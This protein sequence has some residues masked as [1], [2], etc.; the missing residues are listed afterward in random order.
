[1]NCGLGNLFTLKAHLQGIV[2]ADET[3]FDDVVQAI[4]LGVAAQ[5]ENFCDRK[6]ARV[7]GDTF[8]SPADRASFIL[9]RYP[10][11]A[12]TLVEFKADETIGWVSGAGNVPAVQ[13][14]SSPSGLVYLGD[15]ADPG[16]YWSQVRFTFTGGYWFETLEPA[17]DGYP[18]ALPAGAAALPAD[19]LLAW[20]TQCRRV[21]SAFDKLGTKIVDNS[22]AA[23]AALAALDWTPESREILARYRRMTLI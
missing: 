2:L 4:G 9:P 10:V 12:V 23:S 19:L 13:S 21:W 15:G 6:L 14:L 11:E 20:L 18:S 1:M 17:D 16:K 3:R 8:V 22:Q 7:A 5:M